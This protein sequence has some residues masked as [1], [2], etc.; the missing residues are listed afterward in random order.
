[1]VAGHTDNV[2][3]G[4]SRFKDNWELSTARSVTVTEFLI[5]V[6]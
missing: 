6:G 1:M 5:S 3:I 2:P 4:P